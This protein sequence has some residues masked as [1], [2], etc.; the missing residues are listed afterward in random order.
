MKTTRTTTNR[1]PSPGTSDDLERRLRAAQAERSDHDAQPWDYG[2]PV[3]LQSLIDS[4]QAWVLE[5]SVG[6]AAS[7]ALKSGVCFLP[8]QC[9]RD[10]WGNLIP[11]RQLLQP[12]SKGTLENAARFYDLT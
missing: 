12:G 3:V 1:P 7:D 4:G 6:R 2:D 10:F 8:T 9:S 11:A 5:G